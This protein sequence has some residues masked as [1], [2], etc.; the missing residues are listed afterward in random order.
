MLV[1][2][3]VLRPFPEVN[4]GQLSLLHTNEP[5]HFPIFPHKVAMSH[6]EVCIRKP[7][8]ICLCFVPFS[9]VYFNC[10]TVVPVNV[11]GTMVTSSLSMCSN[12]SKGNTTRCSGVDKLYIDASGSLLKSD[13]ISE[14]SESGVEVIWFMGG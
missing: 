4:L 3:Y 7:S 11:V 6:S 12:S 14:P 1:N 9:T 5:M 13:N 2:A 10:V 8:S